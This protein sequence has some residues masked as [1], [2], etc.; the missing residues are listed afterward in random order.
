MTD[1]SQ[2]TVTQRLDRLEREVHRWKTL[3]S[4]SVAL[5]SLGFLLGAVGDRGAGVS[6]EIRARRFLLV[7]THG[8]VR[9]G[10]SVG[11]D[12]SVALALADADE[13]TRAG[14]AVLVDG[15]PRLRFSDKQEKARAGLSVG[16]D[17]SGTLALAG[18]D[19]ALFLQ[20][21]GQE[22]VSIMMAGAP[23]S[24]RFQ[25]LVTTYTTRSAGQEDYR[26]VDAERLT[27]AQENP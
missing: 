22:S 5:L 20:G 2:E 1:A 6:D 15:S 16:A 21:V 25:K 18:L 12:G 23:G 10:L 4:L 14:L 11:S 17:G 9:A 13:K 7:D 8:K 27:R 3:V 26:P 24:Q 19:G